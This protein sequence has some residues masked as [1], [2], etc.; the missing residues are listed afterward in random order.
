[1]SEI[2]GVTPESVSRIVATFKRRNILKKHAESMG[3]VY[4]LDTRRLQQEARK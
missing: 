2:L 4:R 1:M 3:E